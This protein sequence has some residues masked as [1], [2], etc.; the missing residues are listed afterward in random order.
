MMTLPLTLRA[1]R[2][3]V[4]IRDVAERRKPSLSASRMATSET[5]GQVQPLAQ[6]VDADQDVELAQAQVPQDLH[7]LA[8]SRS[9][10]AGSA[11]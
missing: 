11:P 6:E 9:R 5:S 3:M 2:P 7:P 10:S 8:A 1:A 4:W